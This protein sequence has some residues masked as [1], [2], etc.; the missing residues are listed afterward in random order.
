MYKKIVLPLSNHFDPETIHNIIL[1]I[2]SFI[3]TYPLVFLLNKIYS[4][5]DLRLNVSISR[6]T[7]RNPVGLAAGFDKNATCPKSL[8]CFGF[9]HIEVGTITPLAQE[10]KPRPRIFR[11][12]KDSALINRLGFPNKGI[13]VIKPNLTREA[14]RNYVLGINIGPNSKAVEEQTADKDYVFCMQELKNLG[15]YFTINISSPNTQGLRDLT[16][17]KSLNHLLKEIFKEK[18]RSKIKMPIFIK[19]SPD[20]NQNQLDDALDIIMQY[21]LGAIIATNTTIERPKSLKSKNKNET[22]GLSGEPLK[23]IST[24]MIKYI[25]KK[26]KG[27][28]PIIGVGG[29]S[30]TQDAIEKIKA[31]ASLLQIYT[32]FVYEGPGVVKSINMGIL[33]YLKQN[34]LRSITE[35]IGNTA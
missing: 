13:N 32:G 31:G 23:N 15:D 22:G 5:S 35:L 14:K 21:P 18:K 3:D 12:V 29:I 7:F 19:I 8:S 30:N 27:K 25:Y 10:G 1:K 20:L 34:N 11:L 28:L 24:N 33:K 2:L 9:S 6:V 4:V 16:A 17:K 26:T